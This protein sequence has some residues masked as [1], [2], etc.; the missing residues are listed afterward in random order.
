M[1]PCNLA[2]IHCPSA[3]RHSKGETSYY[4]H[5]GPSIPSSDGSRTVV[6]E[7][8]CKVGVA[9][10]ISYSLYFNSL[11]ISGMA[12]STVMILSMFSYLTTCMQELYMY[13]Y[14]V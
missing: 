9:S 14:Y 10:G 6:L 7:S 2:L 12:N 4:A 8:V 11:V 3:H 13:K 1:N 5:S